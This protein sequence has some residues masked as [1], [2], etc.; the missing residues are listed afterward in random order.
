MA[1]I[2]LTTYTVSAMVHLLIEQHHIFTNSAVKF[3]CLDI[4]LFFFCSQRHIERG[5]YSSVP[6][7][8]R[9]GHEGPTDQ[10]N[11]PPGPQTPKHSAL[12]PTRAQI[13]L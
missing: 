8:D 13:S 2:L 6:A 3:D 10:R 4:F 5:H 7:A 11:N 12:L 9:W 1:V